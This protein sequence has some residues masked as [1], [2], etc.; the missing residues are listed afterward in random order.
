MDTKISQ[1]ISKRPIY[2]QAKWTLAT[3]CNCPIP[4]P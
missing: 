3:G 4:T 2:I 1:N